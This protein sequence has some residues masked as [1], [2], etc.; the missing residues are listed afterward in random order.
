M[1]QKTPL[2]RRAFAVYVNGKRNCVAG[3]GDDG[4]LNAMVDHV[5]GNGRNELYLRVGG[6][7]GPTGEHVVWRRQR[8]KAGDEVRVKIVE[9]TSVDRPKERRQPDPK[10]DLKAQKRYVR[11]MARKLGWQ[12]TTKR[13]KHQPA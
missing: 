11:E 4:V 10:Q 1:I 3:I 2:A 7:I 12:V 5:V 8:L 6:L 9:T 13:V